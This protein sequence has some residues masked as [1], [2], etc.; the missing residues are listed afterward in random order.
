VGFVILSPNAK[1]LFSALAVEG[2][3][4]WGPAVLAVQVNRE[5]LPIGGTDRRAI[6]E[7]IRPA[8][9]T[10]KTAQGIETFSRCDGRP[11]RISTVW[12]G[13]S[14]TTPWE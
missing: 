9:K 11:H 7:T 8:L 10:G 4:G 6:E 14:A 1:V 2:I 13:R 3:L 12:S 5:T